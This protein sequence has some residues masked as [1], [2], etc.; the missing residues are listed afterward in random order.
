MVNALLDEY[1]D[2]LLAV[3]QPVSKIKL[4]KRRARKL[5]TFAI[6]GQLFFMIYMALIRRLNRSRLK[7]LEAALLLDS[8]QPREIKFPVFSSVNSEECIAWL[9]QQA[10]EVVV[11]NGTRIVS[12]AVLKCIDAVFLN[13]HCGITPA[14]RGVHGGYWAFYCEDLENAGVTIHV[15][16][17]GIDT[18]DVIYQATISRDIDDSFL[19]YPLKQYQA[20]IPLLKRAIVNLKSSRLVTFKRIDLPS[21][22]WVHPTL[23]QYLVAKW[24]RGVK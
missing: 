22:I 4:L 7:S 8:S 2:L 18:G 9:K 13:I 21:N 19:S 20:G 5:G 17:S 6:V 11:L 23:W 24:R 16:D 15:V 3:E 12:P 14:Y 10:P 1:P